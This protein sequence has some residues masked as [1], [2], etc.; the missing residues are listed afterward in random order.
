MTRRKHFNDLTGQRF[1]RLTVLGEGTF[2]TGMPS[3]WRIRC[4][5]GR[6]KH[7]VQYTALRTGKCKSC[8]CLRAEML[9]VRFNAPAQPKKDKWDGLS[10]SQVAKAEN[11]TVGRLQ[12]R[13]N[14]GMD[15]QAAVMEIRFSQVRDTLREQRS[16]PSEAGANA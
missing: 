8:G 14:K 3:V 2:T 7:A 6:E 10:I 9:A 15:L 4:D 11:V 5:C 12:R 1:G 16:R 13:V